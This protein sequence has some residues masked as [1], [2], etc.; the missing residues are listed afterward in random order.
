M[1]G[2]D[3][4]PAGY[5]VITIDRGRARARTTA[6]SS[7]SRSSRSIAP[8]RGACVPRARRQRCSSRPS[9]TPARP[10]SPRGSTARRRSRCATPVA[11]AGAPSCRRSRRARTRSRVEARAPSGVRAVAHRDVRGLRRAGP[12]PP[13]AAPTGR[14]SAA[15][16]THAGAARTRARAAAR[17]AVDARRSAVTCCTRAPVIA[18]GIVFVARPTSATATRAASSRSISRPAQCAGASPTPRADARRARGRRRHRRRGADRRHACSASTPPPARCAGATSSA[19][20]V[21][22]RGRERVRAARRRRAATVL[23]GNQRRARRARGAARRAAVD[24]RSGA[25]RRSDSQS[26]AAIAIG[27]GVA[28]GVFDRELGGVIAWDRATGARAVA[29]RRRARRVAINASPVIAGGIVYVVNGADEVIAL[30]LATGAQRWHGQARR[31]RLRL[32]QRD[33]RHAGDS[34]TASSSC[35]RCTATSSRSTPRPARELWRF[36]ATRRPAAHHAL[37]RRRARPA[38]R[39]RR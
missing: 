27:D 16:P 7:T 5:R 22:P 33:D 14:S 6:P 30:D 26:L 18:D 11:G 35:R 32:G 31:A 10:T 29:P 37:P 9:S 36:A 4:T 24:R 28:V 3:F 17:D 21:A 15:A 12:P 23:V 34:R 25:R 8:A 2:L 13:A 20:G 38:S 39:R 19:L 1:G